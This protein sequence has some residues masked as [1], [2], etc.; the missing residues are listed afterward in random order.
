MISSPSSSTMIV[1]SGSHQF[2]RL[3]VPIGTTMVHEAKRDDYMG[4]LK[5]I[6]E[7]KKRAR[8][9]LFMYLVDRKRESGEWKKSKWG[10]IKD[11]ANVAHT[12]P[13]RWYS[14][15]RNITDQFYEP[16]SKIFDVY[17][18]IWR[19]VKEEYF[20]YNG[21]DKPIEEAESFEAIAFFTDLG[22]YEFSEVHEYYHRRKKIT[23]ALHTLIY[24]SIPRNEGMI[25]KDDYYQ[26][27]EPRHEGVTCPFPLEDIIY[28]SIVNLIKT[29]ELNGK[30][31]LF[32]IG[33]DKMKNLQESYDVANE[34]ESTRDVLFMKKYKIYSV[35]SRIKSQEKEYRYFEKMKKEAKESY[36]KL[37]KKKNIDQKTLDDKLTKINDY[38]QILAWIKEGLDDS[39]KYLE[40][41]TKEYDLLVKAVKDSEAKS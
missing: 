11:V 12:V 17:V 30:K 35:R 25:H 4:R 27:P 1:P 18:S 40:K 31:P 36:L 10:N 7:S 24:E 28:R 37:T 3:N 22:K 5:K 29:G 23:E 41:A 13:P 32:F 21:E 16:L 15:E 20:I 9:Y 2:N 33:G 14:G 39:K 26:W 6:D 34:F 8:Q 38:S 19:D